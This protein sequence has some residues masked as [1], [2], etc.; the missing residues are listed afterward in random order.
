MQEN[1]PVNSLR[2]FRQREGVSDGIGEVGF[3]SFAT[4][5]ETGRMRRREAKITVMTP[6]TRHRTFDA[7]T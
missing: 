6:N 4:W 3:A 1:L 2:L 5:R 7:S